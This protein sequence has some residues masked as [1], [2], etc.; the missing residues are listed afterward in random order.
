MTLD[1]YGK[2]FKRYVDRTFDS[3]IDAASWFKCE[4]SMVSN[5]KAGRRWPNDLML[6]ATGHERFEEIR[7]AR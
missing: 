4:P 3:N 7:K 6:E 2:L 5:V 1:K